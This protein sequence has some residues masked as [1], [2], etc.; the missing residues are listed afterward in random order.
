MS[1]LT[2]MNII[3]VRPLGEEAAL[4][5]L[6]S[7]SGGSTSLSAAAL[8][9]R[10]GWPEHRARRRL[11][12]WQRAGLV[13][14]RGRVVMAVASTVDPTP[15]PTPDEATLGVV[16]KS[17]HRV[18]VGWKNSPSVRRAAQAAAEAAQVIDFPPVGRFVELSDAPVIGM[19]GTSPAP[20]HPPPT[21][22]HAGRGRVV[23]LVATALSLAT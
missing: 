20:A 1:D 10:W 3:P 16:G 22:R 17:S 15:D 13:R 9:R 12:A 5:W 2:E 8:A 21:R 14:R 11:N 18:E 6:R 4:E 7:Q 19:A 23:V